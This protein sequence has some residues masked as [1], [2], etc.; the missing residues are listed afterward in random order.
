MWATLFFANCGLGVYA[1]GQCMRHNDNRP[2]KYAW[3]VLTIVAFINIHLSGVM[4]QR[5]AKTAAENYHH[6]TR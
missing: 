6:A 5:V 4:T 2:H 3:I 1:L